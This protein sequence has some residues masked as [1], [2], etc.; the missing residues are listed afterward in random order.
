M[1]QRGIVSTLILYG[2]LAAVVLGVIGTAVYKANHWCNAVCEDMMLEIEKL[3]LEKK[4]AQERAT[5]LA[6]MWSAKVDEAARL[7][8]KLKEMHD[9]A[10]KELR[11]R[12]ANVNRAGG[13]RFRADLAGVFRDSANAAND[14]AAPAEG[15][16]PPTAAVPDATGYEAYDE[17]ELAQFFVDASAAYR[18]AV[19]LWRA[20]VQA[21][22]GVASGQLH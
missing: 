11:I 19:N 15:N 14:G 21:Y 3:E 2:I 16:P 6:L 9:A 12:A 18:D 4:A 10:Y 5:A 1:N 7:A 17:R 20:C 22:D 13:V 8:M